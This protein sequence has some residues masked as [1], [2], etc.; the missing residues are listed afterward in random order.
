MHR[1]ARQAAVHT[2]TESDATEHSHTH[3]QPFLN[4][5]IYSVHLSFP[6]LLKNSLRHVVQ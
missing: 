6:E 5:D 2:V 1:R 3:T 4:E